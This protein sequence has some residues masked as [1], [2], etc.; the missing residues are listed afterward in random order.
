M[1][2]DKTCFI[3]VIYNIFLYYQLLWL[4]VLQSYFFDN[5]FYHFKSIIVFYITQLGKCLIYLNE[6]DTC[7][8]FIRLINLAK[9]IFSYFESFYIIFEI[10]YTYLFLDISTNNVLLDKRDI[11][12]NKEAFNCECFFGTSTLAFDQ[13]VVTNNKAKFRSW[14]SDGQR[15]IRLPTRTD[16]ANNPPFQPRSNPELWSLLRDIELSS[17]GGARRRVREESGK[18]VPRAQIRL[19]TSGNIELWPY[20]EMRFS[21]CAH[22]GERDDN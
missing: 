13:I 12:L 15:E 17:K 5:F 21:P 2:T 11:L 10:A 3:S 8:R 9:K 22:L 16:F 7:L 6:P 20:H 4:T 18:R 1:N 14:V 19:W